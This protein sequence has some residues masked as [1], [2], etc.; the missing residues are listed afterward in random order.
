MATLSD[1]QRRKTITILALTGSLGLGSLSPG[2]ARADNLDGRKAIRGRAVDGAPET[3]ELR[4]LREFDETAFPRPVPGQT[5]VPGPADAEVVVSHK[6]RLG[7]ASAESPHV[8]LTSPVSSPKSELDGESAPEWLVGLRL[9]D[10]PARVDARV[11]RYLEFYKSDKR[12]RATMTAWLRRQGRYRALMEDA[13]ARHGLPRGLLYVAMIESSYDPHDRSGPGAVGL[14]QFMPEVAKIYGLRTDHWVDERKNPEK[15][16]EAQ[17]RYFKD[18]YER[19]GNWPLVL[20]AF[21][22]GYGAV[23][24][25]LQKYNTNDYYELCRHENGLPWET[26]LYVPKAFAAAI[27]GENR[28]LFGYDTVEP[29][30]PYQFDRVSVPKST[31]LANIAKA[32]GATVAEI[33][34]LNPELRRDRT[35]PERW[36]VRVPRGRGK[37]L[38]SNWASVEEQLALV[39]VRQGERLDELAKQSGATVRELKS[40]NGIEDSSDVK[41]GLALLVPIKARPGNVNVNGAPSAAPAE[42]II[43]AVPDKEQ[44]EP[45]KKRVFYR[46]TPRDRA[47]DI[48]A[49]F[50]VK[51]VDLLRWNHLELDAPLPSN[52][53]LQVWV[54]PTQDLS[55]VALVDEATVRLCSVG[56]DE[57]FELVE[58]RRGRKRLLH[59]VK[60]GEDLAHIARKYGLTSADLERINRLSERA[61]PLFVGQK[62]VV[63]RNLTAAE[64]AEAA[65]LITPGLP[66]LAPGTPPEDDPALSLVGSRLRESDVIVA[67]APSGSDEPARLPRLPSSTAL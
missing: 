4:A 27:V 41:A 34:A 19:F 39:T 31:S 59:Q 52:L 21:N 14:W 62:L 60:A 37:Q 45:G 22:A 53:V 12:G 57:F 51:E 13:L 36:D 11:I 63:Y 38:S 28:Q 43:V 7:G 10:F 61:T 40:L 48:A 17:M 18:L 66:E 50:L 2:P 32:A 8:A 25:S 1:V 54:P 35:P 6:A 23:L 15:S 16:T 9:P 67:P 5:I 26:V 44:A 20:S 58:A 42:T 24:R 64:K 55:K 29:D 30:Q 3:D 46:T 47:A 56:S 65:K 33:K 49:A